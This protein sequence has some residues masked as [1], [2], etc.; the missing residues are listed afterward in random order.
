[1]M[2][3]HRKRVQRKGLKRTII[4]TLIVLIVLSLLA[5]HFCRS[6][7]YVA[8]GHQADTLYK[9]LQFY[10]SKN[11]G[12]MP[13]SWDDL[14]ESGLA[15]YSGESSYE[16]NIHQGHYPRPYP[17]FSWNE[18]TISDIRDYTVA[19]GVD[20]DDVWT[21][22]SNGV[23]VTTEKAHLLLAPAGEHPRDAEYFRRLSGEIAGAMKN[24]PRKPRTEQ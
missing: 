17:G 5:V 1:M 13:D 7:A 14:V 10:V 6:Q 15:S 2:T 21:R 12:R 16:L 20:R 19:F 24:A 22:D 4:K 9:V 18:D 23:I 3:G 8:K 11:W